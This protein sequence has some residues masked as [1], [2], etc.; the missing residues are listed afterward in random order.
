MFIPLIPLFFTLNNRNPLRYYGVTPTMNE[1]DLPIPD[2][3]VEM[4]SSESEIRAMVKTPNTGLLEKTQ[5]EAEDNKKALYEMF[6]NMPTPTPTG[7]IP[8]QD[9]LEKVAM[10]NKPITIKEG[11]IVEQKHVD[12]AIRSFVAENPFIKPNTKPNS[13][14]SNKEGEPTK[15]LKWEKTDLFELMMLY[16]KQHAVSDL[17]MMVSGAMQQPEMAF[18]LTSGQGTFL[19]IKSDKDRNLYKSEPSKDPKVFAN[20]GKSPDFDKDS[21]NTE[22]GSLAPTGINNKHESILESFDYEAEIENMDNPKA[23]ATMTNLLNYIKELRGEEKKVEKS[24][25]L[26]ESKEKAVTLKELN[27]LLYTAQNKLYDSPNSRKYEKIADGLSEII[28]EGLFRDKVDISRREFNQ[29]K[30]SLNK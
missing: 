17:Q 27:S 9:L 16:P 6:K 23:K 22:H 29:I 11:T 21:K 5:K 25:N 18:A 4:D 14:P 19:L 2:M 28:A 24:N 10:H 20:I 12:K 26:T 7:A 8:S 30:E 15:A 1:N 13:T 3:S